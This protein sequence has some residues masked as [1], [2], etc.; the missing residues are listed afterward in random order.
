MQPNQSYWVKYLV[1]AAMEQTKDEYSEK[2]YSVKTDVK[3]GNMHADLVATKSNHQIVF[4][5]KAQALQKR[6]KAQL[7]KLIRQVKKTSNTEFRLVYVTPPESLQVEIDDIGQILEQ[8]LVDDLPSDL[9]MLSTHTN[10]E[11]VSD[12]EFTNLS[13]AKDRISVLGH[14]NVSVKLQYGSDSDVDKGEGAISEDSFP[15]DFELELDGDLE[16]LNCDFN[17]DTTSFYGEPEV[18]EK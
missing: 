13:I 16:V 17:I 15:A 8:A 9:D 1:Q 14:C 7:L 12:V 6:S 11:E 4:E 10:V 5:F 3:I 2:G 18:D